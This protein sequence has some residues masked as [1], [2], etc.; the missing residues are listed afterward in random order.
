MGYD[1]DAHFAEVFIA[2]GM[3]KMPM[4]I[5]QK[6]NWFGTDFLTV[7]IILGVSGAN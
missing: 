2:T 3:I 5:E 7:A 6:A 4:G 1:G